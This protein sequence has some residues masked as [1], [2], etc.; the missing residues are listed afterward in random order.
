MSKVTPKLVD[1]SAP[2]LPTSGTARST[3]VTAM[4]ATAANAS[5]ENRRTAA[6]LAALSRFR[7]PSRSHTRP[8]THTPAAS[9]CSHWSAT[10]SKRTEDWVAACPARA[11]TNIAPAAAAAST[12]SPA[13]AGRRAAT[14][15]A[16]PHTATAAAWASSNRPA[17]AP[18]NSPNG[19]P[20]AARS[21]RIMVRMPAAAASHPAAITIRAPLGSRHPKTSG[22]V[23][24]AA[25]S[26]ASPQYSS[27]RPA[28]AA[29]D[30][31][32]P[33][34]NRRSRPQ[35]RPRGAGRRCRRRKSRQ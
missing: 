14:N 32:E 4:T 25:A 15:A 23:T 5:C 13:P 26:S 29:G 27:H 22:P 2:R 31:A 19:T 11:C 16:S 7:S 20:A 3:P 8:P 17:A 35:K 21:E 28:T 30:G 24:P 33:I 18:N 10:L 6:A 12:T 34:A 9:M 1:T